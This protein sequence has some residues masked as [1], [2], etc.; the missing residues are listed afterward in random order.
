MVG[1]SDEDFVDSDLLGGGQYLAMLMDIGRGIAKRR[2]RLFEIRPPLPMN[3]VV[4]VSGLILLLKASKE[5]MDCLR[6]GDGKEEAD[7][8]PLFLRC[9]VD[10]LEGTA[11]NSFCSEILNKLMGG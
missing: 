1:T 9:L 3:A 11:C 6:Y 7:T 8:V 5:A 4:L 2:A 10:G